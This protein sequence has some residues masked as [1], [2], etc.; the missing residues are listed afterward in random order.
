MCVQ[1]LRIFHCALGIYINPVSV[2][3]VGINM[4]VRLRNA[5]SMPFK[6]DILVVGDE[7][8]KLK[9]LRTQHVMT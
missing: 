7:T 5:L 6:F 4:Y 2:D 9:C 3:I 8:A 1:F